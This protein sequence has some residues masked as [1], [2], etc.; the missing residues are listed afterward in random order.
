MTLINSLPTHEVLP[1]MP[2]A[3]NDDHDGR[4]YTESEIDG[5]TIKFDDFTADVY[6]IDTSGITLTAGDL[7]LGGLTDI[8]LM[9]TEGGKV[10]ASVL[11]L[12]S[13]VQGNNNI[14]TDD[15]GSGIVEV[16]GSL[17]FPYTG[18]TGDATTGFD[19]ILTAETSSPSLKFAKTNTSDT[20]EFVIDGTTLF[21]LNGSVGLVFNSPTVL[22]G[23]ATNPWISAHITALNTNSVTAITGDLTLDAG[24]SD[25]MVESDLQ[26]G[27]GEQIFADIGSVSA[28]GIT[29]ASIAQ[30]D[31][32]TGFYRLANG[33]WGWAASGSKAF[34][35]S[36]FGFG[37]VD[38]SAGSPSYTFNLDFNTGMFRLG[39]DRL[40][41]TAAGST[42]LEVNSTGVLIG[43]GTNQTAISSTGDLSFAGTATVWKDINIGAGTLS[44]PPGLQP[45]IDNFV[46]ENGVDTGIAT[47]ALAVGEGLS[48]FLE[49]Q[50][51]Y[52]EGS[53]ITFHVHWQGIAAPTGTDN[54]QFQLTYTFCDEAVTET[55]AP[56]TVITA[57][58][59][60]TNQ[61]SC[62]RTDFTAITGTD[63]EIGDQFLFTI[64]RIAASADE[65]GGEALL[66]TVGIHYQIDT[67][68]SRQITTK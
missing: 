67:V 43:D 42:K 9:Q 32:S 61:Y 7:T 39:D 4:Y 2:S 19:I 27:S 22:L 60:I 5:F 58:S 66:Q 53:D 68:G 18:A 45:G 46:D 40:G 15:A 36:G 25:V 64:Q 41:L 57:E 3:T 10:V 23:D 30:P 52:K 47:F 34:D 13:Y 20:A 11:D 51:D 31:K 44:G 49:I 6:T 55:L 16:N 62:P 14:T 65:Y 28:P 54:V 29:I 48:G 24:A 37:N 8:R 59:G 21:S 26:M 12:T 33:N 35:L 50:H 56:V 63:I 1:D 38:G 17:L